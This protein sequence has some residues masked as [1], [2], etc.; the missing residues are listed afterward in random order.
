MPPPPEP[1]E[2]PATTGD[3]GAVADGVTVA[4]GF[5]AV[6]EYVAR[7]PHPTYRHWRETG[8]ARRVRFAGPVPLAGWVVTEYAACRAALADPRLSKD[9]ATEAFARYAGLPTGGPGGGLTTHMLNS[10]PPRH[11]RL[12]RLVQQ[13]FTTRRVAALRPRIEARVTALLDALEETAVD[14][15]GAV[16]LIGR[17]AL[18]LPLAVIFDLLGADPDDPGVLQ[19]RGH[20]VAGNEG[21]GEV[22]VPTAD[23]MLD[24]LRALV[25]EKRS[26]PG[27]DLLSALAAARDDG[28]DGGGGWGA[29]SEE[30]ITSMA[31]LL[32]VAGHQTTVNL[33]ANGLH[34][35]FTHPEQLAAVRA[36]VSLVPG[37]IEE[38]LRHESPFGIAT[39]RYTT[40]PV[41]IQGT[42][43]PAGEFVQIA[44]LAANRDPEVFPDPD[45]FDVTRDTS[46]HLAF[47]HG[48]HH[49]LGAPLARL[50]AEIAFTRL[51]RRFPA[52][53]PAATPAAWQDNPRHRG[54]L[55]LPAHLH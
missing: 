28:G 19:V 41:T 44:L 24:R 49:C 12:R 20:S 48:I 22:S 1:V 16:D 21:D 55:T 18:P 50:Q 6:D 45:R 10:D 53:R 26:R 51:L 39:L 52:L 5:E 3:G 17:F 14:T 35:L 54:L 47:G 31:F 30:E 40:E 8:G 9:G 43:I 29:L 23:A 46:G 7:D 25:E 38:V 33:I 2:T 34:A 11:T 15:T 37:L 36:D 4:Y 13:A 27:D 32:V 42:A